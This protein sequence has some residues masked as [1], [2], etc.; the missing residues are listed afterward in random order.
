MLLLSPSGAVFVR[1][2]PIGRSPPTPNAEPYPGGMLHLHLSEY[3]GNGPIGL[4]GPLARRTEG[5]SS[6]SL[7]YAGAHG[8]PGALTVHDLERIVDGKVTDGRNIPNA[9]RASHT[10][11]R[12]QA[13]AR[14][15][16]ID[17]SKPSPRQQWPGSR[18][19]I[20]RYSVP[21]PIARDPQYHWTAR[22]TPVSTIYVNRDLVPMLNA[23]LSNLQRAGLLVE[24]HTYDGCWVIRAT[25]GRLHLSAHSWGIAID[26]NASSN[27]LGQNPTLSAGFVAA[28][29]RAGFTWGGNFTRRDGMHFSLGF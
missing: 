28:F 16:A 29:T 13:A 11:T 26:I 10:M 5:S 19:W 22:G 6:G 3:T 1:P 12:A 17:V 14:Y 4:R 24:L 21:E 2:G 18:T 20:V 15:G 9:S 7:S 8:R 25:R 27:R 23:A